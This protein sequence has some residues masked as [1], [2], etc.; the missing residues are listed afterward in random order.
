MKRLLFFPLLLVL[1]GCKNNPESDE[2]VSHIESFL[3][4]LENQNTQLAIEN[5][6]STNKYVE[7][8]SVKTRLIYNL[9]GFQNQLGP[10]LDNEF[11]VKRSLGKDY[12]LYRYLIKYDRQP[13]RF[14]FVFYKPDDDW[15]FHLFYWDDNF[16]EELIRSSEAIFLNENYN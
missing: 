5:L 7:H 2:P 9:N 4:T 6:F 3:E 11:L 15:R 10:L 13:L 16:N 14:S 12:V 8:D 1:L